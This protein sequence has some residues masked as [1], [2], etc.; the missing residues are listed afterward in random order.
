MC[1][2]VHL[3]KIISISKYILSIILIRSLFNAQVL[4]A[5]LRLGC[6]SLNAD[7]YNNHIS[8]N[9]S[10]SCGQPETAEHFL[11]NCNKY[12]SITLRR[13]TIRNINVAYNTETLL[14]GCPLYS[15]D[16]N[17]EIFNIVHK[18]IVES[19]RF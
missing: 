19:K 12:T 13:E 5:C 1:H 15:D 18:F 2:I 11:L 10:C 7:L 6:S 9:N 16:V 4:H 14:K 8:E 3:K 17:G